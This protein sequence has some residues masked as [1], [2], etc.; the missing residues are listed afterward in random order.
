MSDPVHYDAEATAWYFWDET[1][2]HRHGPYPTRAKADEECS[3][4]AKSLDNMIRMD[5]E[6]LD[7]A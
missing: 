4:Y 1:W 7:D 3:R 6:E 5:E 2:A